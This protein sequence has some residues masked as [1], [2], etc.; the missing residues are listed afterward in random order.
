MA[1]HIFIRALLQDEPI[2]VYG[3]CKQ[4][5]SNTFIADCI[6]GILLVFEKREQSVGEIFNLGGGEVVTLTQVLDILARL[7]GKT[8]RITFAQ[9]RPGDQRHTAA[10]ISKMHHLL[11]YAP[12]TSVTAGLKAQVEWQRTLL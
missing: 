6:Q 7:T 3:Y 8:P 12:T 11:G 1:Y 5:R 2:T 10:D 4:S 9:A